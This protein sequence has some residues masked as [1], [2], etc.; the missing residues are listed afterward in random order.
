[1]R[2]RKCSMSKIRA[3]AVYEWPSP[4]ERPRRRHCNS[5]TA[6]RILLTCPTFVTP[7]SLRS[8]LASDRSSR[9]VMSC[10]AKASLYSPRERPSSQVC[11]SFTPQ[12]LTWLGAGPS[13]TER[14][15]R[16]QRL[17]FLGIWDKGQLKGRVE[18][19]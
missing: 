1:M 18:V 11:T 19:E 8:R 16:S 10:F 9:P 15:P 14:R 5:L 6:C 17:P 2:F 3:S 12:D 13:E 4:A 7:S